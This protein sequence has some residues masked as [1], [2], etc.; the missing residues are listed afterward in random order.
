MHNSNM[1]LIAGVDEAGRGA[2]AGPV[3][4]AAVILP[5][6]VSIPFLLRDSKKL[7]PAQREEMFEWI[8]QNAISV[9]IGV[10]TV[11][12]INKHNILNATFM[13]MHRAIEKL[14]PKPTLILIDG[15][16]FKPYENIE[17]KC[18]VGGDSKEPVISAASIVAKVFRDRLMK[19]LHNE[20]PIYGWKDNK[21]YPTPSHKLTVVR[22]GRSPYHRRNFKVQ[23]KLP[24]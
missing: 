19:Q 5:E 3:V 8:N 21:G 23:L 14:K 1:D 9:G 15:N 24:L 22:H 17:F 2:I 6:L 4:A 18:I 12:E 13:A 7:S 10:A 16:R 11:E 20:F